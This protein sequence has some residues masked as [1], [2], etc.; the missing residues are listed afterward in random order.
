MN[1]VYILSDLLR[2]I[3]CLLVAFGLPHRVLGLKAILIVWASNLISYYPALWMLGNEFDLLSFQEANTVTDQVINFSFLRFLGI[4]TRDPSHKVASNRRLLKILL[5]VLWVALVIRIVGTSLFI[6]LRK[7]EYLV[8]LPDFVGDL[9]VLF[10]LFLNYET[11]VFLMVSVLFVYLVIKVS[12]V[13]SLHPL[14]RRA[15]K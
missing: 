3:F 9:I 5:V 14:E 1:L 15:L 7:R 12:V 2:V 10:C 6:V 13:V 11:P 8:Y 4:Y